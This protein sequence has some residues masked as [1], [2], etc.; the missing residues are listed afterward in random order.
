[1]KISTFGFTLKEGIRNVWT[2]K[3]FSIASIATMAAC[4]FLFGVFYSLL[5][6]FQSMVK[7]VESGVAITVFFD[8]ETTQ[9]RI[10]QIGQEIASREEVASFNYVSA[11]EAWEEYKMV[12]FDG[13]ENAAAAFGSDNP[14]ANESNYEIYMSDIS[15]QQVL[16]DYLEGLDNV[17]RVRQSETVANTLSDVNKLISIVSAAIIVILICVAVFLISNT[18]RTGI[19]VRKE[20]IGI[21]K[22][23]GATD[24]FV[25]APFIVEGILIGLVGAII[26]LAILYAVY[27]RVIEYVGERFGFLSNMITFVSKTSVFTVLLPVGLILGVGIGYAGS[28]ITVHK[29]INV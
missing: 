15:Q 4:I 20:E 18:V 13:D 6:N 29:H 22:M 14:L 19:T 16:V 9:A 10:D 12:Y 3:I 23:I 11:E 25:R 28:R 21:M 5:V 27:G 1:M 24:F 8:E 2:N 7:D 17:S 26:P